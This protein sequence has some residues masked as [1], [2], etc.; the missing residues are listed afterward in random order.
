MPTIH[1]VTLPDIGDFADVEIIEILVKPGATV[2]RGQ[3]IGKVGAT[4]RVTGPHLHFGAR[5]RGA[6]IDPQLLLADPASWP[7]ITP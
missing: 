6:K 3:A 5:W 2:Q 7:A 1:E 4:G